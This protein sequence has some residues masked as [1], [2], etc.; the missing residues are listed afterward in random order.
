MKG[1]LT[2]R[3]L[4]V[5]KEMSLDLSDLFTVLL[6]SGYGASYSKLQYGLEKRRY[7]RYKSASQDVAGIAKPKRQPI[8]FDTPGIIDGNKKV[9]H[10]INIFTFK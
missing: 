10:T 8:Q 6:S 7:Q 9:D 3:V 4:E 5:A 2:L 1:D